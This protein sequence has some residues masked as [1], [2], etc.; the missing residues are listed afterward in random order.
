MSNLKLWESVEKTDAT[1]TKK[2]TFGAKLT[3]IDAQYQRKTATSM[4]G[5]MGQGWGTRNSKYQMTAEN[6]FFTAELWY[7]WE[8][9]EGMIEIASDIKVKPDCMKSVRTD[10]ITK[11]LSELGFNADVFMGTFD[12]NKYIKEHS[13]LSEDEGKP[14]VVN[15]SS[16]TSAAGSPQVSIDEGTTT[17]SFG[18]KHMGKFVNEVDSSYFEWCLKNMEQEHVLDFCKSVLAQRNAR[19]KAKNEDQSQWKKQAY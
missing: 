13:V 2:Q 15:G 14:V 16:T 10:A 19:I 18:S 8:G 1:F 3:A 7:I 12:G 6:V 17:I 9:K 11:G 5:P 4:F